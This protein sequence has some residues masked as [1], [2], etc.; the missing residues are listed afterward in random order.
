MCKRLAGN[1][2]RFLARLLARRL[3]PPTSFDALIINQSTAMTPF[4]SLSINLSA[5]VWDQW[6][7]PMQVDDQ[8]TARVLPGL[9]KGADECLR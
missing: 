7:P 9:G 6:P 5:G 2:A 1:R 3:E 4:N 8:W